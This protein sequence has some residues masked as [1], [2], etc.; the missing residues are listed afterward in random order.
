MCKH[1][2]SDKIWNEAIQDNVGVTSV[3]DKMREA[4]LKLFD[5]VKKRSREAPV[6]IYSYSDY[7]LLQ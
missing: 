7:I 4:R 1:T 3:M 6:I 2:R 5:H